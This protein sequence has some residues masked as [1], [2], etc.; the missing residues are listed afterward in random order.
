MRRSIQDEWIGLCGASWTRTA[1]DGFKYSL[2]IPCSPLIG[3]YFPTH[4]SETREIL[5]I[6]SMGRVDMVLRNRTMGSKCCKYS[7]AL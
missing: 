3:H 6:G 4:T 5:C 2:Y 1:D 7:D